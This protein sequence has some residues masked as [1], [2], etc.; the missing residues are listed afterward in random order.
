MRA[1]SF[2]FCAIILK[3]PR[4]PTLAPGDLLGGYELLGRVGKGG[5]A[6]VWLARKPGPGGFEKRVAIKTILPEHGADR[7]FRTM[8]MDEARL[9]AQ[10]DHPNVVRII[11]LGEERG[12][13]FLAMEYVR[14]RSLEKLA[15]YVEDQ[16]RRVP[17]AI[18]M[19]ILADTCAGLHAAHEL[20][21]DGVPLGVVHRDVSP[22][23]ILVGENGSATLIDFGVAKAHGRLAGETTNGMAK[24]KIRYMAPEQALSRPAD[25]RVDVWAVGAVAYDLI[26]GHAPFEAEN[27]IA[28]ITALIGDAP[29]RPFTVRVPEPIKAVI[30]RALEKDPNKR[31]PSAAAMRS[32]IED[33]LAAS[34]LRATQ[35]DVAE[36]FGPALRVHDDDEEEVS[37]LADLQKRLAPRGKGVTGETA[38]LVA[39]PETLSALDSSAIAGFPRERGR[40]GWMLAGLVAAGAVFGIVGWM[41]ISQRRAPVTAPALTTVARAASAPASVA[42]AVEPEAV[43]AAPSSTAPSAP[44]S[45]DGTPE[46]SG[47]PTAKVAPRPIAK[48]VHPKPAPPKP[49]PTASHRKYDDTIQ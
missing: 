5:F 27:D 9:A 4:P 14:G 40:F 28:R 12:I 3:M 13:L 30:S 20:V 34:S 29:M 21:K 18:V 22:Q 26:Q 32:A 1:S 15:R 35:E 49:A 25:R 42:P 7:Q 41:V 23:N 2:A 44:A 31:F 8:F 46:R 47:A 17:I 19:R 37:S 6:E 43:A 45:V 33:A 39:S 16:G 38:D 10:I 36:F 48:P 11:E 24:G